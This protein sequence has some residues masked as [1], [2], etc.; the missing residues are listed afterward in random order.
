MIRKNNK[1][2]NADDRAASWVQMAWRGVGMMIL[3]LGMAM[4]SNAKDKQKDVY[5]FGFAATF[6]DS[7]VYFTEIQRVD[8][9]VLKGKSDFL[10]SRENYSLQ[11]RDHL[12]KMGV[13]N[14]TCVTEFATSRKDAEKKYVKLRKRYTKGNRYI[15][16]YVDNTQFEYYA[17]APTVV[18][19]ALTKEGRKAQEKALKEQR[20]AEKKAQRDTRNGRPGPPPGGSQGMPP[21][22]GRP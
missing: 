7:I 10:Y 20:K 3:M 13:S 16:K 6:S 15:I 12:K 1:R 22:E 18:E 2:T 11:L 8:S 4:T 17:I 19:Q 5:L 9:A 21:S 14:P